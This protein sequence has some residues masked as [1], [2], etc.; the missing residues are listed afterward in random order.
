MALFC[1]CSQQTSSMSAADVESLKKEAVEARKKLETQ[2]NELEKLKKVHQKQLSEQAEKLKELQTQKE[3]LEK[4]TQ[5][6]E[7]EGVVSVI[8]FL[9]VWCVELIVL[10]SPLIALFLAF[11]YK[12]RC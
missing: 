12:K 3:R 7:Q 11:V 1:I 6:A 8:F 2:T 9:F 4:R 10:T 5:K